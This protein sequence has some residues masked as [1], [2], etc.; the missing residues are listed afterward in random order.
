MRDQRGEIE[1]LKDANYHQA[2]VKKM[3]EE[4]LSHDT[5]KVMHTFLIRFPKSDAI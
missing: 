5:Q 4:L 1:R 3:A 2:I